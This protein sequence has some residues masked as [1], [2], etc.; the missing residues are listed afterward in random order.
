MKAVKNQKYQSKLEKG[1]VV[2]K[3]SP[4]DVLYLKRSKWS[5]LTTSRPEYGHISLLAKKTPEGVQNWLNLDKPK[6]LPVN[7]YLGGRFMFSPW[8]VFDRQILRALFINKLTYH[9]AASRRD[10]LDRSRDGR[11]DA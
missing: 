10:T 2:A 8:L 7:P 3:F 9:S 6:N 4:A 5:A 11:P 1:A